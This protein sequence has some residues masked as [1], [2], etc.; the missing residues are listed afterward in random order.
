MQ[1]FKGDDMA[2]KTRISQWKTHWHEKGH[3]NCKTG[4]VNV[5]VYQRVPICRV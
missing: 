4:H 5:Y 3:Y 2:Y 1:T